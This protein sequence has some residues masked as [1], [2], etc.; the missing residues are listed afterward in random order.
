MRL[1]PAEQA[2]WYFNIAAAILV[3]ARLYS[4]RLIRLYPALF[5][6]ILLDALEQATELV[7][8]RR[9]HVYG[10]IYF[11]GQS[12][13]LALAI[14][15]VLELY[16][17]ALAKQ[18]ALAR[19][20]RQ[21]LSYVFLIAILAGLANFFINTGASAGRDKYPTE[22]VRLEDTLDLVTLVV[23]VLIAGFLLWFPVRCSR[24]VAFCLGG[25]VWYSFQ[26]WAGLVFTSYLPESTH[27]FSIAMLS[28]SLLCLAV[29]ATALRRTGEVSIIVTG[30]RW[31]PVEAERLT[32]QLDT[33]NSRLAR[34]VRP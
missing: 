17:L 14:L 18:P 31:N 8:A 6:Y 25:F 28:A 33:I 13:K 24:N 27:T 32:L 2:L 4:E 29:W 22:F 3:L 5:A 1:S 20:G 7:F 26:R 12:F 30:H 11:V 23:V 16:Q 9:R 21:T 34:L 15:V 19:F 10:E